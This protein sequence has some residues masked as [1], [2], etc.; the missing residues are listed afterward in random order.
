VGWIRNQLSGFPGRCVAAIWHRPLFSSGPHQGDVDIRPLW[1]ALYDANVA[2]TMADG[3]A[4]AR[5]ALASGRAA[6]KL[7]QF[8]ARTK[9]LAAA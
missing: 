9:E 5:E 2:A 4:L 8:V 7:Q 1:R 3:I 6:S